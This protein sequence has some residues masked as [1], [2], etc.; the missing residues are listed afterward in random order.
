MTVMVMMLL[1]VRRGWDGP[2]KPL[3]AWHGPCQEVPHQRGDVG[4]L[5]F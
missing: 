3:C 5:V 4:C 2:L 1:A